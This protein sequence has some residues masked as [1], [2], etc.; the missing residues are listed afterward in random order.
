M[1]NG[2]LGVIWQVTVTRVY[3]RLMWRLV[4]GGESRQRGLFMSEGSYGTDNLDGRKLWEVT[5]PQ[6]QVGQVGDDVQG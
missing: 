5:R 4:I 3:G 2:P 1:D 6:E